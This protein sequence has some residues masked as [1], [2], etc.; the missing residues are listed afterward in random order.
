[1]QLIEDERPCSKTTLAAGVECFGAELRVETVVPARQRPPVT[2]GE[3]AIRDPVCR[4]RGAQIGG[5]RSQVRGVPTD[6]AT[7]GGVWS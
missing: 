7:G 2:V 5:A 1:M 6:C 3:R 4:Q